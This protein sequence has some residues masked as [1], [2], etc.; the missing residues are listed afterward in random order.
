MFHFQENF[1]APESELNAV[2]ETLLKH[3]IATLIALIVL[4]GAGYR[5]SQ[6]GHRSN[7]EAAQQ[8]GVAALKELRD[9]G[10][11]DE[12]EYESRVQ[13]LEARASDEDP[14]DSASDETGS[15]RG[16]G[17]SDEPNAAQDFAASDGAGGPAWSNTRTVE[18]NDPLFQM[19][20][21]TMEIPASWKFEGSIA[22]PR[23][24][25]ATP[26]STTYTAESADGLTGLE[27]LPSVKWEWT[28]DPDKLRTMEASG[29]PGVE[30]AT[31]AD[32]LQQAALPQMRPNAELVTMARLRPEAEAALAAEIERRGQQ[33]A[34][35]ASPKKLTLEGARARIKYELNGQPVEEWVTTIV[36]C[37]EWLE[38]SGT[39]AEHRS[40]V[41]QGTTVMRAP[42]GK[43]DQLTP[44]II[45]LTA[46]THATQQWF[47]R[48]VQNQQANSDQI[49]AGSWVAQKQR[50]AAA[51]QDQARRT[52]EWKE[53]EDRRAGVVE[54]SIARDQANSERMHEEA[55]GVVNRVL[56]QGDY[57][58][59]RTGQHV[60]SNQYKY[61][62]QGSDGKI[63][64]NNDPNY[65]P[66]TDPGN[67]ETFDKL[68]EPRR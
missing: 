24:C 38:N 51:E 68:D 5:I 6:S 53:N 8:H 22:R 64:G 14:Q 15:T 19:A 7:S 66:N 12:Q 34:R 10:V 42:L 40:C 43:L 26:W 46:T 33:N 9:S 41:T 28:S 39:N 48:L 62:W 27:A 4:V 47:A 49:I 25:H 45:K 55:H 30:I 17:D 3:K 59:R 35:S 21:Q 44:Q 29:C 52:Q 32:Y 65:N 54:G 36:D 60:I 67:T 63:Y 18:I 56:G 1:M 31:A 61:H 20:A 2:K 23:G 13:A 16:S 58:N 11:I 50:M 57:V 37:Q